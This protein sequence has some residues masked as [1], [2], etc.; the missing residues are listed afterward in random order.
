MAPFFVLFFFTDF[1]LYLDYETNNNYFGALCGRVANRIGNAQFTL[2]N[3]T[4]TC[5]KNDPFGGHCV[6][7][8]HV[9]FARVK[10]HL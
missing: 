3:K 1:L 5:S 6:H 9:G 4:Y 7:G 2:D 8:G 10:R